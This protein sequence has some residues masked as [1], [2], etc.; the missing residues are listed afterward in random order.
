MRLGI[1]IPEWL[2]DRKGEALAMARGADTLGYHSLWVPE[3]AAGDSF[4]LGGFLAAQ[5]SRVRVVLG[6]LAVPVR[7]PASLALGLSTVT[8]LG[9]RPADLAL[10]ASSPVVVKRW[11]GRAWSPSAARMEETIAA[12]R[13]ILNGERSSY[14]GTSVSTEGFRL[15]YAACPD[16]Q[17]IVAAFGPKM[18]RVAARFADRV[19][20]N[21]VTPEQVARVHRALAHEATA[22]GRQPPPMAVWVTATLEWTEAALEEVRRALVNYVPQPGY[23]DMLAEAGFGELVARARSARHPREIL[24]A[25]PL[26]LVD[27]VSVAGD[28]GTIRSR[29]AQYEA[30]GADEVA[31]VP[32]TTDDPGGTRLLKALA[33]G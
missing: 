9:E 29:M 30:A 24:A 23:R 10:G 8:A 13:P 2:G 17:V 20:L 26:A 31:L 5:T 6:P 32:V 28:A 16:A 4:A 25:I 18:L 15:T 1:V 11:H 19:V 21:I 14:R 22:A 7:G 3:M 12:L 33:R 27:A